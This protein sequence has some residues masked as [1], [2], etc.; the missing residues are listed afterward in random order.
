MQ[1]ISVLFLLPVAALGFGLSRRDACFGAIA[2]GVGAA[3]PEIANAFS[4]QLDDFIVEPAQQATDGK[5]DLNAA[6]VVR[7]LSQV[8][9]I[10]SMI[11]RV[12]S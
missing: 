2:F 3:T 9:T 6:F 11:L 12:F 5:L 10:R 4:Q 1:I 8:N 7:N